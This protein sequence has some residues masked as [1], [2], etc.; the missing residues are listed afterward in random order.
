MDNGASSYRRLCNEGDDC[1]LVEDP[2]AV[3]L[4]VMKMALS[5]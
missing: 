1:G 5:R 4:M 2:T 3:S